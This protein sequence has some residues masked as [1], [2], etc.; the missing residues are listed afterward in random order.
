MEGSSIDPSSALLWLHTPWLPSTV[1]FLRLSLPA[2]SG[3]SFSGDKSRLCRQAQDKALS[4]I[5]F[6]K[7]IKVFMELTPEA[8]NR[9]RSRANQILHRYAGG[10]VDKIWGGIPENLPT[11]SGPRQACAVNYSVFFHEAL[12][13]SNCP[14][15][16]SLICKKESW[17]KGKR[18]L[19]VQ[20]PCWLRRIQFQ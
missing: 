5:T 17:P 14:V 9:E 1:G 20:A 19:N 3:S 2:A 7:P 4:D 12:F 13:C 15:C 8:L 10:S 6:R 11:L 18:T 16:V